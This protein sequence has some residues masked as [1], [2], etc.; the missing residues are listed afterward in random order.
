MTEI[1]K[2]MD[3]RDA[4]SV[5]P[6][7]IGEEGALLRGKSKYLLPFSKKTLTQREICDLIN[8]N[9]GKVTLN[10]IREYATNSVKYYESMGRVRLKPEV[11]EDFRKAKALNSWLDKEEYDRVAHFFLQQAR[12]EWHKGNKGK[13]E[14]SDYLTWRILETENVIKVPQR[15]QMQGDAAIHQF[16][17][18]QELGIALKMAKR[19]SATYLR[20]ASVLARII[21]KKAAG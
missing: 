5:D 7:Q 3:L 16:F 18:Q 1:V 20:Q 2:N 10:D 21:I 4:V 12:S 19:N 15:V 14:E 8:I 11:K 17:N 9:P 13:R 6:F